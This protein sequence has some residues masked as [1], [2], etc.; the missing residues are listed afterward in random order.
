V[1][2]FFF[3]FDSVF[4]LSLFPILSFLLSLT[5]TT[6]TTETMQGGHPTALIE[7]YMKHGRLA[8]ACDLA[9]A[10]ISNV[11]NSIAL[12]TAQQSVLSSLPGAIVPHNVL[13]RLLSKCEAT[14]A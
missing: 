8:D 5:Q 3:T 6:E 13:D 14:I 9:S 1:F 7:I 2:Y 12:D 10:I 4:S 11:N